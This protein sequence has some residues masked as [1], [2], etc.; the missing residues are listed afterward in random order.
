MTIKTKKMYVV[1]QVDL[2][3]CESST[4]MQSSGHE[5]WEY[6]DL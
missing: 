6:E 4:I 3:S 1:P 5:G 2:Y